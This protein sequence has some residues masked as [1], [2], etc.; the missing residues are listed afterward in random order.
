M[1]K[2]VKMKKQDQTWF[3]QYI[4]NATK[5]TMGMN[6]E[7]NPFINDE[8]GES[9]FRGQLVWQGEQIVKSLHL[10]SDPEYSIELID[11]AYTAI[12]QEYLSLG[13]A[14]TDMPDLK[15]AEL[16]LLFFLCRNAG[17]AS[18]AINAHYS[19]YVDMI[20]CYSM[21]KELKTND[22]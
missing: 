17:F 21:A 4:T 19:F 9:R 5:I 14:W 11:N 3:N 10:L 22:E 16:T 18:V 15:L 12:Y 8:R 2:E 6:D 1:R 7:T 20:L 13:I